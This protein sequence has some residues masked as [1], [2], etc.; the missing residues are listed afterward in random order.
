MRFLNRLYVDGLNVNADTLTV[1]YNS[2]TYTVTEFGSLLKRASNADTELTLENVDD[3]APS[4][5]RVWKAPAYDGTTMKLVDYT[6]A[7]VDF[8]VIMKTSVASAAFAEREYTACGYMILKDGSGNTVTLYSDGKTDSAQAAEARTVELPEK[9]DDWRTHPQD[10]KLIATTFDRPDFTDGEGKM[11]SIIAALDEL[12]CSATLNVAGESLAEGGATRDSQITLLSDAISKGFEI[13]S[14]TWGNDTWGSSQSELDAR[15]YD[16]LYKYIEDTQ[17]V[18]KETL[19][20]T[21]VFLRPPLMMTNDN[22]FAACKAQDI[23][24]IS[25][26]YRWGKYDTVIRWKAATVL[27][28][29]R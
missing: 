19:G 28:T 13:G 26:N 21:P 14:Y 8:T 3:T 1:T 16:E 20:V 23:S 22:V 2:K 18:I 4:A 17:A 27:P 7:Y 11:E 15:S 12:D 9:D 24:L 25:A 5:T 6:A 10:F 29:K